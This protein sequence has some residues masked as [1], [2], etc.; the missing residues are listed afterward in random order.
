MEV[1]SLFAGRRAAAPARRR[2]RLAWPGS[3]ACRDRPAVAGAPRAARPAAG[4][5]RRPDLVP[6]AAPVRA[7]LLQPLA[8][9]RGIAAL[10][11]HPPPPAVRPVR[12]R[13][14]RPRDRDGPAG[15]HRQPPGRPDHGR[16]RDGRLAQHVRHRHPAQPAARGRGRGVV[17]RRD[18]RARP[19]R[20]GSSRSRGSPRSSRRRRTTRRSCSTSSQSLQTGRRTAVGSAILTSLDAIAEI[21]PS[22]APSLGEDS[23]RT[24][25]A[26]AGPDGGVRAGH[27]RAADR[28]GQQRR[29]GTGRGGR[30]GRRPRGPRLHDRVRHRRSWRGQ[31]RSAGSSS[32]V[33][34]RPPAGSAAVVAVGQRLPARD[35]RGHAEGRRRRDRR[36]VLP[37]RERRRARTR[38]SRTCRPTSS[39][40]TR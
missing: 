19:P 38:S 10:V 35:R 34:N 25:R 9:P 40:A 16:P 4:P 39:C 37:R 22:V 2:R 27:R 8:G 1:T 15:H 18:A 13:D 24:R 28:R 7:A 29:P 6:A 20:S 36:H 17:V 33:A 23:P 3:D 31:H 26:A 5:G 21:D 14:R 30:A 32:S 12:A 11:A